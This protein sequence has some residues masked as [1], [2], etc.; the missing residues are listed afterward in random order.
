MSQRIGEDNN[1][2]N[3]VITAA[4]LAAIAYCGSADSITQSLAASLPDWSLA[5]APDNE[6]NGNYAYIA[7]FNSSSSPQ[8]AVA[9][10]GSVLDFSWQTFQDWFEQDFN[11]FLQNN[12][13]YPTG[14]PQP[15][16]SRGAADG[17]ADLQS[18]ASTVSA[19]KP[20]RMLDFLMGHAVESNTSILVTGH[21]LGGG[22]TTVFAPWLYYQI[23]SANKD[24]PF[25]PVMTFAAPA[26]GNQPFA[27]AYD[28]TFTS[29]WRYYNALDIV[30]MASASISDMG[31]LYSPSPEA[32]QISATYDGYTITLQ[33]VINKLDDAVEVSEV[34]N[35]FSFYTQTNSASGSVELN[36]AGTLFTVTATD[37]LEQW[38]EQA[39]A[40]HSLSCA[41]LPFLGGQPF[42]CPGT[43]A[44][45]PGT[46]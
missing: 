22:L 23:K 11:V 13:T 12:W 32:S 26:V 14:D 20:V 25:M 45:C 2:D 36:T 17:L 21:S 8:Y 41:Y 4:T 29:S 1:G 40:Q 34:L 31:N 15:Q 3:G 33:E 10:R 42:A 27:E 16:I 6:I 5:W 43:Q 39:G 46:Q 9:I 37:P 19:G 7:Y 24:V 18:L 44:D 28:A 30:P 38:F 35:G